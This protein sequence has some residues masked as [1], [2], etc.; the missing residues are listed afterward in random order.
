MADEG[1][2]VVARGVVRRSRD[3]GAVD[4]TGDAGEE[5][6]VARDRDPDGDDPFYYLLGGGVE[7]G[8]RSEDALR[9]EFRE[10]LG[11][12]LAD[13]AY[14][15]TYEEVFTFDGRREH[16]IWRVYEVE[17]AED[18]PYERDE[19][20]CREPDLDEEIFCEWKPRTAFTE[21]EE[22]FHPEPLLSDR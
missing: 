22:R 7:F 21:G 8:E 4:G 6:L 20:T 5:L 3:G 19:F 17:I 18:W 1:I 9:R 11:V 13:V 15:E 14:R 2:R 16:E 10:E 12:S